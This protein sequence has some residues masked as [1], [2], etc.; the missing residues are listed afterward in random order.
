MGGQDRATPAAASS[1]SAP[2]RGTQPKV[3]PRPR[4]GYPREGTAGSGGKGSKGKDKGKGQGRGKGKGKD[5]GKGKGAGKGR[6]NQGRDRGQD[7]GQEQDVRNNYEN[8]AWRMLDSHEAAAQRLDATTTM[9]VW[10]PPEMHHEVEDEAAAWEDAREY[11]ATEQ[12]DEGM[13]G[14]EGS[15]RPQRGHPWGC[16]KADARFQK[17]LSFV[18]KHLHAPELDGAVDETSSSHLALRQLASAEAYAPG[19]KTEDEYLNVLKAAPANGLVVECSLMKSRTRPIE[20]CPYRVT[21]S[22]H[23]WASFVQGFLLNLQVTPNGHALGW[24]LQRWRAKRRR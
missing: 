17:I 7:H 8:H 18:P 1:S 11:A 10:L 14:R 2:E 23:D 4:G 19:C 15:E 6:G 22:S 3:Q 20:L 21:F 9:V 12:R 13:E 16:S 24:G 5:K